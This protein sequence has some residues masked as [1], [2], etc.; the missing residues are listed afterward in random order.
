MAFGLCTPRGRLSLASFFYSPQPCIISEIEI[1]LAF[2][3][4]FPM[5]FLYFIIRTM[6]RKPEYDNFSS[7]IPEGVFGISWYV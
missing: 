3:P 1:D 6:R 7:L 2:C 5:G 4:I